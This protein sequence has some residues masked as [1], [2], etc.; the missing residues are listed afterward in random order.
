VAVAGGDYFVGYTGDALSILYNANGSSAFT[1]SSIFLGA[2]DV[3]TGAYTAAQKGSSVLLD[4]GDGAVANAVYANG[5]LYSVFEV[6]PPGGTQPA[7]HWVKVDASSNTVVAQ[8][9]ITGPSG[10]AAF[11]PSIA[12]DANGDVLVNYTVSSST[13]Y[14]AAYASVMP[15]GT[16]SFLAPVQYGSSV[17]PET[18]TFGMT[19]NVIRWGDYSTAVADPAAANSFVVSNEIVPSAQTIFNNAP[20]GTVTATITLSPGTSGAVV[21]SS[22]TTTNQTSSN[23]AHTSSSQPVPLTADDDHRAKGPG[24]TVANLDAMN[25]PAFAPVA[26]VENSAGTDG[27]REF[28]HH[29]H[30]AG[31]LDLLVNYMAS[32]AGDGHG[33]GE[34][35]PMVDPTAVTTTHSLTLTNH[36]A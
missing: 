31:P 5:F 21:A 11:N 19:N 34:T 23:A 35:T 30:L 20:W 6:V 22:S 29:P 27:S 10:A 18:A 33:Y 12:V 8:G 9:N 15:A 13:M 25:L 3:G 4:A 16:S 24:S 32:F 1:Q 17:A 14:P 7:V 28:G 26:N 36:H 2:I